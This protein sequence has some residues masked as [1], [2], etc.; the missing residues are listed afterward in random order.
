MLKQAK[1]EIIR[2]DQ[3]RKAGKGPRLLK[4]EYKIKLIKYATTPSLLSAKA[5]FLEQSKK[6][7]NYRY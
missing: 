5:G 6:T 3:T 7:L 2:K 1:E 4:S